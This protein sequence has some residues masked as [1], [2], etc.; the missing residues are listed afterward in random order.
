MKRDYVAAAITTYV[1]LVMF[2]FV[3]K[4]NRQFQNVCFPNTVCIRFCCNDYKTCSEK[5][6][7]DNFNVSLVPSRSGVLDYPAVLRFYY[8]EPTCTL[9]DSYHDWEF[10]SVRNLSN[11]LNI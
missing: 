8:G 2:Y 11:I 9:V 10:Y 6:I 3:L 7:I 1:F 4:E 5:F